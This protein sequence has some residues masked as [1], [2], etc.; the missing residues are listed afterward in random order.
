MR[1]TSIT[2]QLLVDGIE[3]DGVEHHAEQVRPDAADDEENGQVP[4]DDGEDGWPPA[5]DVAEVNELLLQC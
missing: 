5:G 1:D 2:R 3:R 4:E